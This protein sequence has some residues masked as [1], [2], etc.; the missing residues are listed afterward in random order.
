MK[1]YL[2]GLV[3]AAIMS[4]ASI[5]PAGANQ[6]DEI[7]TRGKVLVGI[8]VG[9]PPFGYLDTKR[10]PT[11]ADVETARLLAGALGVELEI[12]PITSAN[13][14]PYLQTK[15]VDLV[16]STFSILPERARSV[17]FSTPYGSINSVIFAAG[18]VKISAPGD[19][20]G[21][22]V[23]VAR[24]TG[25]ETALVGMA[26]EG[27]EIVRFDDEASALA[28]L[29]A[30]QVDAYASADTIAASLIPRFPER[31]FEVKFIIRSAYYSVGLRRGEPDLL[32]WIN[33]FI[34]YHRENGDLARLYKEHVGATL[35]PL[36]TL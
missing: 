19:L 3:V 14:I 25:N 5:A 6:L 20:S 7:I 36:P 15:R 18:D 32:N 33:T 9:A 27:T 1:K 30:S 35:A 10:N 24:G 8:D 31:N 21:K 2:K 29:A 28:A 4:F 23:G 12:V 11:G 16:M 26:P 34:F 22:R 17:A 13:R